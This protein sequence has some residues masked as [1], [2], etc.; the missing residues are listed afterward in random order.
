M[1]RPM[2]IER[3]QSYYEEMKISDT[4]RNSTETLPVRT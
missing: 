1:T 2:I 4:N 3:A